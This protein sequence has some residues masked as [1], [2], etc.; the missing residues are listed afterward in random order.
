VGLTGELRR[1]GLVDR[2]IKEAMQLGFHRFVVPR[3]SFPRGKEPQGAAI[4]QVRTV[5]EAVAELYK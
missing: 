5:E 1:V 3:G 2:R 4:A